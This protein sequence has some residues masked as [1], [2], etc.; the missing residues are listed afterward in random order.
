MDYC[1]IEALLETFGGSRNVFHTLFHCHEIDGYLEKHRILEILSELMVRVCIDRPENVAEYLCLK[2]T[3]IS[4][5]GVMRVELHGSQTARAGV[6]TKLLTQLN[7]PIIGNVND[8]ID[9]E[10]NRSILEDA[11]NG[12]SSRKVVVSFEASD[13][14]S[15]FLRIVRNWK[16]DVDEEEKEAQICRPKPSN[17]IDIQLTDEFFNRHRL[18]DFLNFV[19]NTPAQPLIK[20]HWS[21]RVMIVGRMGAGRK[22]QGVLLAKQFGLRFIDLDYLMVRYR[23]LASFSKKHRL[24]F[25]GFVQ[26]TLLKPDCLRSG[27]VI[28]CNVISSRD[29]EILMEKFIFGPNRIIFLHTSEGE[30]RRRLSAKVSQLPATHTDRNAFLHYHMNLYDLNKE[31][32]AEYFASNPNG[33]IFHVNGDRAV[34]EIKALVGANLVGL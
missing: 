7:L 14:S 22:T 27:Y 19:R 12:N 31:A 20:A 32:F 8:A 13:E 30:C 5:G 26:E 23:Q 15:N 6:V 3:E 2:L 33:K 11:L 28:V 9:V 10:T 18:T 1:A 24:G 21:R 17:A 25:W 29:C 4:S 34:S 16:K